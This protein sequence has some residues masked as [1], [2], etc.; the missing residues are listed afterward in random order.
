VV[1]TSKWPPDP[2][3]V[4]TFKWPSVLAVVGAVTADVTEGQWPKMSAG[5][6]KCGTPV[7][8]FKQFNFFVPF[9]D[10]L[11]PPS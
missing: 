2:G 1:E 8:K 7:I 9:T 11:K 10:A 3:V 6:D 4:E 5:M